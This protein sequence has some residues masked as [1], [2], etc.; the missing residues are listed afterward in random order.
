MSQRV[1]EAP[2]GSGTWKMM[3]V[4]GVWREVR[5]GA[6]LGRED[7]LE[8]MVLEPY[9]MSTMCWIMFNSSSWLRLSSELGKEQ[10]HSGTIPL[11]MLKTGKYF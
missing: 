4:T 9:C 6:N 10:K 8:P 1:L 3:L 11:F 7:L 2:R 5:S